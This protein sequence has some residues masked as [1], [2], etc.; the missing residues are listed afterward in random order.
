MRKYISFFRLRFTMGLQYRIAALAGV[1]TQFVWGFLYI[2]MYRAFYEGDAAS[3]P[4]SFSATASYIW[5]QQSFFSMFATWMVENEI[6]DA[7]VN[8]NISGQSTFMICGFPEMW[9]IGYRVRRCGVFRSSR[10]R[11][12]CRSRTD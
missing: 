8:G 5:L 12:S 10:S 2:M 1:A 7:I 4:M 11:F 6:F 3:F 9:Q